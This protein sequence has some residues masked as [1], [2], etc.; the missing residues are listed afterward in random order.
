MNRRELS[1]ATAFTAALVLIAGGV[2]VIIGRHSPTSSV[3]RPLERKPLYWVSPMAPNY[4]RNKPGKDPMGMKLVPV[5]AEAEGR[6]ASIDV[7]ISPR[8]VD[9]I[10]VRVAPVR[11]GTMTRRIRT[12]GYVGY[13]DNRLSTISTRVGGWVQTLNVESVGDSVTRGELLYE[14]YSPRLVAA[15]N[16]Y[17]A[18]INSGILD[19]IAAA[20][21]RLRA[22]G[23]SRR[24]IGE[25]ERRHRVSRD[26][27]RYAPSNGVVV[28]LGV[29][30]GSYVTPKTQIMQLADLSTV[31]VIGEV[32]ERDAARVHVG[33]KVIAHFTAFPGHIRRGWVDYVYPLMSAATRTLKVRVRL[34]NADG[35]LKPNMYARIAILAAPR[36]NTVLIPNSALIHTG[37]SERVAVALGGGRFDICPVRAGYSS[38]GRTQILKGLVPG[39]KV[40]VSAQFLIDSEANVRAAALGLG[41]SRKRCVDAENEALRSMAPRMVPRGGASRNSGASP[42]QSQGRGRQSNMSSAQE[43]AR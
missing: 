12:V 26:V 21:Q 37:E 10:G 3:T 19:L 34:N 14:L 31:W 25:L 16:E 1:I 35:K 17:L 42:S 22:L 7:R 5:Y 38:D 18:D 13:D 28:D 20:R 24:Q 32:D 27:A 40:V 23:V 11:V 29:R 15:Q 43:R 30:K 6:K 8:V 4:R 2:G 39:E 33:Q 41:A 9:N 36:P